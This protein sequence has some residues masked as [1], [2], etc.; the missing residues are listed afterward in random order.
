MDKCERCGCNYVKKDDCEVCGVCL[1]ELE[2]EYHESQ[3]SQKGLYNKYQIINRETGQEADGQYFVLKP[4]KDPAARAALMAYAEATD[5]EQLAVDVTA[6]LSTLTEQST[7]CQWLKWSDGKQWG[8]ISCPM[9]DGAMVMTYWGGG[10]CYDTFT[11]P[12]VVDGEIW[13]YQ[14]DH[15]AD[16]WHEDSK[17]IGVYEGEESCRFN[18]GEA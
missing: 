4:A 17:Y 16:K 9:L 18:S 10:P 15:D 6:W 1:D 5:N 3:I 11:A 13:C 7:E 12:F 14:Y 2:E 8:A